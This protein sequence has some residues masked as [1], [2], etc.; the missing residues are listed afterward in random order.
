M[1]L[2]ATVGTPVPI[3]VVLEDGVQNQYP[4]TSIYAA[5]GTVPLATVDLT[6]K[7]EGRYEG[8]WTPSAPGTYSAHTIIYS[9]AART[10]ENITY[11]RELE[12]IWATNYDK[13]DLA[14]LL[15][16]TLGMV[17]ENAFIDN[18]IHDLDGQLVAARVRLFD[19]KANVEAATDGGAETTGLIAVYEMNTAYESKGQMGSYRM[20]RIQ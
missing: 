8:T 7:A 9:D 12:H 6:H 14:A 5:G 15:I 19:S 13:D 18:T 16:R 2:P 1:A 10:I 3:V 4:R 20:K 11:T 17:H